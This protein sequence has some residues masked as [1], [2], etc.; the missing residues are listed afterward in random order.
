[1]KYNKYL[2]II[3]IMLLW[4]IVTSNLE[5]KKD[6]LKNEFSKQAEKINQV[7]VTVRENM[8]KR[9]AII[10]K[11]YE[12]QSQYNLDIKG[13]DVSEGGIYKFFENMHYYPVKD[14]FKGKGMIAC[15]GLTKNPIY[16]PPDIEYKPENFDKA[17]KIK[18]DGPEFKAIKK[19]IRLWENILPEV[20]NAGKRTG[21]REYVS[22]YNPR[23]WLCAYNIYFDFVSCFP[24]DLNQKKFGNLK[25]I[26]NGTPY[27]NLEG[28]P[29]WLE[30]V[31]FDYFGEGWRMSIS[32]PVYAK[33]HF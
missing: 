1:M 26:R 3:F 8:I 9:A 33:G 25:G 23:Y 15:V 18:N 19:E 16:I 20:M 30:S 6:K 2:A 13:M 7:F 12:N 14:K 24:L 29:K 5:N 22:W 17:V 28:K 27:G 11:A 10:Q 4:V 31:M 21:Y 32:I